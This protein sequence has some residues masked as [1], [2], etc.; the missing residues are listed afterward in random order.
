MEYTYICRGA[1]VVV[2]AMLIVGCVASEVRKGADL[3]AAFTHQVSEEGTDFVQSRTMLAQAR[4]ANIAMLDVN[5]V[6]LENSVSRDI[7][8]WKNAGDAGKQ[9][10]ELL[11]G[12]RAYA[13]SATMRSAELVNL[14]KQH[15]NSIAAAKSAVDLRQAELSKVSKALASLS[16]APDIQAELMFFSA[17]FKEVSTGIKQA[18]K[19]AD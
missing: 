18:K 9:R 17:Y 16:R 4:R 19:E 7:E 2:A 8:V 6:E 14:R 11:T 3:L 15:D 5:A 12:I 13:N 1:L 10:G